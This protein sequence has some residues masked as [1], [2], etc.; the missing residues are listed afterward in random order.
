MKKQEYQIEA[1]NPK[2]LHAHPMNRAFAH[3]GDAWDEFCESIQLHG[4]QVPLMVRRCAEDSLYEI[5]AGHRRAAAAEVCGI[6]VVPCQVVTMT[7]KDALL[8]LAN[9]NMQRAD[10]SPVDEARFVEA[11]AKTGMDGPE[12]ALK[13]S[14]GEVWV[15]TRQA[16]L[17]LDVEVLERVSL[18]PGD[19]RYVSLG[20]VEEIL[21]VPAELRTE[22]TQM[23]LNPELC[24]G[25]LNARQAHD[26]LKRCLVEPYRL[27]MAWEEGKARLVKEARKRLKAAGISC[28]NVVAVDFAERDHAW[29]TGAEAL[30]PVPP[31]LIPHDM[32]LPLRALVEGE[33]GL[34]WAN[35]A[36]KHD[37]PIRVVPPLRDAD[38]VAALLVQRDLCLMAEEARE[39][40][41]EKPW[42]IREGRRVKCEPEPADA[43]DAG[44]DEDEDE[45]KWPLDVPLEGFQEYSKKIQEAH[46]AAFSQGSDAPP[47]LPLSANPYDATTEPKRWHAWRVGWA[48]AAGP[49]NAAKDEGEVV[50]FRVLDVRRI[51]Q[52]GKLA[53]C[54]E[55][56]PTQAETLPVWLPE[57]AVYGLK[58]SPE[59]IADAMEW[60]LGWARRDG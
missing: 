14:R 41:G 42:L 16:L 59:M 1:L 7:D 11:L 43:D 48:C 35:V 13:L 12:I 44:E 21:H 25:A 52:L 56:D 9:E 29:R 32:P 37:L 15:R 30:H 27:R 18:R 17:D 2:E 4:V 46:G 51:R 24:E 22:A 5:L 26:V 47:Y 39:E 55:Q 31:A 38:D 36:A 57:W 10:L 45:E 60:V 40:H 34:R 33:Y 23:V 19:A 49:P 28:V 20:A 53:V 50:D 58:T 54:C 6:D 8:F 3:S